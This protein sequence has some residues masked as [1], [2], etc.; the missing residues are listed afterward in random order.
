MR[1]IS[2]NGKKRI[3]RFRHNRVVKR[4]YYPGNRGVKHTHFTKIFF[5]ITL[6]AFLRFSSSLSLTESLWLVWV[7]PDS[8]INFS[9]VSRTNSSLPRITE[10]AFRIRIPVANSPLTPNGFFSIFP[11]QRVGIWVLSAFAED[12]GLARGW[13]CKRPLCYGVMSPRLVTP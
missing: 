8:L 4:E 5:L 1:V 11:R 6:T 3:H 10:Y 9:F 2:Y 7:T 13:K 12:H